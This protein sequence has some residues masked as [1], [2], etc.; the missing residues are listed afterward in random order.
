MLTYIAQNVISHIGVDIHPVG[1]CFLVLCASKH[2]SLGALPT[3][4]ERSVVPAGVS[5]AVEPAVQLARRV[6]VSFPFLSPRFACVVCAREIPR[7]PCV[8]G[9]RW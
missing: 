4:P 8:G 3:A 9:V 5:L 7:V 6:G 2:T 1:R